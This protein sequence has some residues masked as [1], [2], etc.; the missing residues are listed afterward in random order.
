MLTNKNN[1]KL[2]T[3]SEAP[4]YRELR[5]VHITLS[6]FRVHPDPD[7]ENHPHCTKQIL[8]CAGK[9]LQLSVRKLFMRVTLVLRLTTLH[10]LV[11]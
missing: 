1:Y 7:Q 2:N 5:T 3:E 9:T 4:C 10:M 11:M 8:P 6:W